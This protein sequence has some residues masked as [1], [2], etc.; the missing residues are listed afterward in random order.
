[1]IEHGFRLPSAADNRPLKIREFQS[2]I[3]QMVYVSATPGEREL[4]HLCELTNQEIPLGLQHMRGGGGV[5]EPVLAKKH[6]EAE[7]MY[8][9]LQMIDGIPRMEIRPTGLLDPMIEVRGTEGQIADLLSEINIRIKKGERTLVTVL[10]IKFAEEVAAYLNKMGTK[11]HHLHSEIDTIERTEIINALRIGHIDVIVGI[12]L[13]REGLDIPEV[14]LVAIFDADRQGFLR[15]ERSLLQTIGRASRNQNGTVI[16]YADNMSPPM[17]S[18]IRQTLE[19]RTRQDEYNSKHG[20][21]PKT[22]VKALPK[23]EEFNSQQKEI[24]DKVKNETPIEEIELSIE[25]LKEMM[26]QSALELDFE[27]AAILRDL[28]T[29]READY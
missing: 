14:S 24:K 7:S 9:M 16:L 29:R 5:E 11:A 22:I 8:N 19:R 13:L 26:Q 18:S 20:I 23:M 6:T 21:T 10:T 28:I 12:N 25:Q 1:L 3:P 27:R 4:L 15:N 17:A 2:L